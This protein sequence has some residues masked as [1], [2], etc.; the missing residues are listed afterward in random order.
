[1]NNKFVILNVINYLTGSTDEVYLP[2]ENI[3]HARW[4]VED[5][6]NVLRIYLKYSKTNSFFDLQESAGDE[7]LYEIVTRKRP[8]NDGTQAIANPERKEA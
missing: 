2:L 7:F 8:N 4:Q 1:M 5:K 6:R 3:S